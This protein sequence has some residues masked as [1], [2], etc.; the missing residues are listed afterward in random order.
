MLSIVG[1]N[2][3]AN[4][5]LTILPIVLMLISGYS[6]GIVISKVRRKATPVFLKDFIYGSVVLNFLF[7]SGFIIF[8]VLT[9]A[10]KEYFTAFTYILAGLTIVGAYFLIKKLIVNVNVTNLR[11]RSGH[12]DKFDIVSLR[13][14]KSFLLSDN[15]GIFILFGIALVASA[16]VYQAIIIYY[17]PIYSEYDSIY[18]YLP[19][20][21]SILLGNGLN[22]DFY[23]G[24]DVNMRHPPFIQ[25]VNAWLIHSFEYSSLRMF[26]FYYVFLATIL[27]Y[28]TRSNPIPASH[29]A[30]WF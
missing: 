10:A 2:E 9:S 18:R 23:L 13:S 11:S 19:I 16:L 30:L 1:I 7:L 25:A 21:K 5:L 14:I 22:H 15:Q 6:V 29:P 27:V 3:A 8:G 17:H 4:P 24:S 28:S 12:R 20:S 26:P